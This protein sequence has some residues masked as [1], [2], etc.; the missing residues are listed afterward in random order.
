LTADNGLRRVE[1]DVSTHHT[2]IPFICILYFSRFS[3]IAPPCNITHHKQPQNCSSES[4]WVT[5]QTLC[6]YFFTVYDFN[7]NVHSQKKRYKTC[8]WGCTFS[9]GKLLYI[10]VVNMYILGA[11]KYNLGANMYIFKC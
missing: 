1:F 10:L 2:I 4:L 3:N 11:N 6:P 5:S 9:K 8:H 7:P